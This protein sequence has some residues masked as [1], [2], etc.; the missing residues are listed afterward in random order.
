MKHVYVDM[1]TQL[2][3]APME[4]HYEKF[5]ITKHCEA[6]RAAHAVCCYLWEASVDLFDDLP[7]SYGGWTIDVSCLVQ[8]HS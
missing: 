5:Q 2:C 3:Q 7:E 6:V 8:Q 4:R 1:R